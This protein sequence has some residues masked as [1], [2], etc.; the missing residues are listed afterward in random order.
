MKQYSEAIKEQILKEVKETGSV[1][2]VA[3]KHGVPT[4]IIH[5][6]QKMFNNGVLINKSKENRSLRKKI[7]ELELE[8]QVL[9]ELLK[10]THQ[11]WLKE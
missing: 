8:N 2:L 10:K 9:K 4:S 3:K 6:W 5:T 7:S 1:A 11:V